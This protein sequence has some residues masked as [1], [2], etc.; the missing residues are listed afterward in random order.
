[1]IDTGKR[2]VS[3]SSLAGILTVGDLREIL[4]EE[5]RALAPAQNATAETKP[6][7]SVREAA[8]FVGIAPSTIRL[9]IRKGHLQPRKVGRRVIIARAE[10]ERFLGTQSSNVVELYP[11]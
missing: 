5:I 1:M 4:R 6:Y 7:L 2:Q 9:Y 3:D 10:L 8:A 11:T